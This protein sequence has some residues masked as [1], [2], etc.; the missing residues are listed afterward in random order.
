MPQF[1]RRTRDLTAGLLTFLSVIALQSQAPTPILPPDPLIVA[2]AGPGG[3]QVAIAKSDGTPVIAVSP[4]GAGFTGGVRVAAG[5]INGDGITDVVAAMASNGGQVR[6]I[7]GSDGAALGTV[8][9]FGAGAGGVFVAMGDVNADGHDDILLGAGTGGIAQ[10]IDGAT[11]TVL[12]SGRPFPLPYVAGVTVAMGDV[13]GDGRAELI[14]G[15]T[16]GGFVRVLDFPALAD[17][18]SGFPYGPT[19]LGGVNVAAGDVNGDGIDEVA[20]APRNAGEPVR[21]YTVHAELLIEGTP[22]TGVQGVNLAMGDLNGDGLDDLVMGA[23]PGATPRVRAFS[24]LDRTQLFD[25]L[26][27]DAGFRGGVWVAMPTAASTRFT[28]PATATFT[29]GAAGTFAVTTQNGSDATL[30]VGG[31]LPAGVTFIDNGNGAG[32]LAG[33]PAAGTGGSYA[34]TFVATRDGRQVAQQPFTLIVQEPSAITSANAVTFASGG[35]NMFT[36]TTTGAPVAATISATGSLPAGVTFT[37]NGTGTATLAGTP[38]PGSEGAYPLTVSASNG[39][40]APATQ[41]FTLTVVSSSTPLFTSADATASTVGAVGSFTVMTSANPV[42][43]TIT[44]SGALPTGVTFTNHG[45]GTASLT[46][47]PDAGSAG[48]YPVTITADNGVATATQSFTLTVAPLAGGAPSFTSSNIVTFAVGAAGDFTV[49]TTG[50]PVAATLTSGGALPSGVTFT[51]NGDGTATLA[52]T[53]AAGTAGSYP[54]TFMADNGVGTATQ[55]FTLTI[56]N[57]GSSPIFTSGTTTAFVIDASQTFAI[58]TAALPAVTG[59][60][61]AGALPAGVTFTDNGDGTASLAGM[62]QPGTGGAYPLTFTATNGGTPVDQAFTLS[63]QETAAITSANARAF[64]VGIAD[65]FTVTTAGLPVPTIALTGTLP[66][67]VSYTD[68]GDGTA[69]IE[70]TAAAGTVGTYPVALTATNGVGTPGTQTFTLA[71]TQNTPPTLDAIADPAAILE[72]VAQQTVNL[73]G[74]GAGAGDAQ[75]L[76]VTATASDPAIVPGPTVTY[77]TPNATGTLQYTPVPDASGSVVITVQVSDGGLD[78]DLGTLADNGVTTRTFTVA[79]TAVNDPPTLDA[80]ADP[81][82][83]DEDAGPQTMNLSGISTGGGETQPLQVTATSGNA[84]LVPDPTVTYTSP[85]ATGSLAYTPVAGESG[86]AIITVTVTDGGLDNDLGT[87]GDNLTATDTFTVTVNDVDDPPTLDAI[88]DPAAINEDAPVQTVN[89]SGI[90]AGAGETATL[91]VT[92]V[93]GNPALIPNP[94][95]TYTSPNATG[96][97]S[98]TPVA[99][100]SGSAVITVTVSDGGATPTP[101]TFT[102]VVNDVND[103]PTFTPGG[104]QTI[105]EDASAQT[106]SSFLGTVSAGPNEAGQIVTVTVNNVSTPALFSVQP[107]ISATG[108]LTYTPAPEQF[109]VA[110]VTYTVSDNGGT[111]NGGIDSVGPQSF[112]IT[113]SAVNDP[114]TLNAIADPAAILEDTAQQTVNLSGIG[115]GSSGESAQPLQITAASGNTALIPNPAVTYVSPNATGSL[116]YTPVAN[117]FGTAVITVTVTDGGLDNDLVSTGD[118]GTLMRTF[119]VNVTSVNDAPS[120]TKGG[121]QTVSE[122]AGAQTVNPWATSVSAGPGEGAQTV[123][124]EITNNTNPSLFASG[125]SVSSVGVLS[126]TPAANQNGSATITLRIMDD[127]GTANGGINA[128]ATQTFTITVNPVNDAPAA[129]AKSYNAQANMLISGL[130][131]LLTGVTDAD[132]GISGCTPTFSVAGVSATSPAGGIISNLDTTAGSFDFEP[133]PGIIGNVTFTYIV[134]D[135]G[136]PGTATSAP[137]TVTVNVAGPVIWFVDSTAPAGGNGTWTGTNAKA[138]QTL[139]QAAAVDASDH[140]VFVLNNSG[141]SINYSGGITLNTGEWL[142][143]QGA[144]GA[145]FD[146]LMS[147]SPPVG[148]VA[149][150]GINGVRPTFGGT[151]QVNTQSASNVVRLLGFNLSTGAS[152]ALTNGGTTINGVT[153]SLGSVAASTG[154]AVSITGVNNGSIAA[155]TLTLLTVSTNGATNGVVLNNITGTFVVTGTG[156]ANSGGTIQNSTGDGISLTNTGSVSL[157][158]MNIVASGGSHIDATSVN[159]LALTNVDTDLSTDAGLQGNGV[160]N[161]AISGGLFDR[162]GI[163][164]TVCNVNGVN[165]TNLLGTSSVTG[166]TFRRSNTVQFR[167]NNNTATN[168][169]G[170]PDTLT[171]S[172]NDFDTHNQPITGGTECWGDHLSVS[173]DTGANF[174]LV[175]NDTGG[176]NVCKT[177]GICVQA[178]GSGSGKMDA[179]ISGIVSGGTFASGDANTAGIAVVGTATSTVTF[180]VSGNTTLGTGS[181]GMTFN[182]FTSGS[183]SGTVQDNSITHVAGP[184]TDALQIVSHGDGNGPAADGIATMAFLN[185]SV[186]GNFQRGIRAQAAFGDVVL[187]LT[188][189]GNTVHGTDPT[190]TALRAIEVEV[191]GSGGGTA[192]A[193]F[194]NLANN[195]AW[196]DNGNAG[197]RLFHRTGYTFSLEDLTGSGSDAANITNWIDVVKAN[198]SNGGAATTLISGAANVFATH[199]STPTP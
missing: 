31:T 62:P 184:G 82:A 158:E 13:N 3:G 199:V 173:A 162:G 72:D 187:N 152:T 142:V 107:A 178:A 150:P 154:T 106:V 140:R 161:L 153:V 81:A 73:T 117:A 175:V 160:R 85:A 130:T 113:I 32:T 91:V 145:S 88:A 194:L 116:D 53:A 99:N 8:T 136:C 28:S 47:I 15:T 78:N 115:T 151:V 63:V 84:T 65:S 104:N 17:L 46:G 80:I 190:A 164:S 182:D 44:L 61:I 12:G 75:P 90:S 143:G 68:N 126:Y 118:N 111:A 192:D 26:A 35:A 123:S 109:G 180:N 129:Q 102:V 22:F 172:N 74:I 171:V 77:T 189:T 24:I 188:V 122:D 179:Q 19:F 86:T 16:F 54:L 105:T 174:R 157:T 71:V 7:S 156:T 96:S 120:F 11:R 168:F 125:P 103:A 149:R 97:L 23:G 42:A 198:N 195:N 38:A 45:N 121:D 5:D 20:V 52:G 55:L 196:M 58:T 39:L 9:P 2:G 40:G 119:T 124:F 60:T 139:A 76:G 33:T 166:A 100:T 89:L 110:T 114:P 1:P 92:A 108:V 177:S 25:G 48:T 163:G 98:Y 191:G 165:V 4:F 34:L 87:P 155:N 36:I 49:T 159:G 21:V 183:F 197:Y 134:S 137:A 67:G 43:G 95:V 131:G 69:T 41:T 144:T 193:L 30:S 66:T 14:F 169:S 186:V 51:S 94:T 148:T 181:V 18:A 112:T 138:F 56:N 6:A 50:S 170:T 132:S 57:V 101:R 147:I 10:L 127:G 185:N 37:N 141:S 83:I 59:M 135:T 93:S 70:G 133:P 146:G 27:F 167:V 176:A 64:T 29:A 79:V 128:S